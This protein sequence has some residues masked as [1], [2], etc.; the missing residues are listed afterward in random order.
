MNTRI[1][2]VFRHVPVQSHV[3]QEGGSVLKWIGVSARPSTIEGRI[4]P[5]DLHEH[6][7]TYNVLAP[8]CIFPAM[9]EASLPDAVESAIYMPTHGP[10]TGLYVATC[11]RDRC[12]YVGKCHRCF[13]LT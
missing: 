13:I 9:L 2:F 11:A 8:T 4:N 5:S 6:C 1:M 7:R 10:Y 12:L 3:D